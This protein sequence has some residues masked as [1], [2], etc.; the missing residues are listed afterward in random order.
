MDPNTLTEVPRGERGEVWI[1][2]SGI[3]VGYWNRPEANAETFLS[4]GFYRTGD[5]VGSAA[6]LPARW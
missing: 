2:S 5:M 1:R 4:D 6:C 3:A